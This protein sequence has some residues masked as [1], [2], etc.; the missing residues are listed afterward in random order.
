MDV[1]LTALSLTTNDW[2]GVLANHRRGNP[3]AEWLHHRMGRQE[4][5]YFFGFDAGDT[6]QYEPSRWRCSLTLARPQ[7]RGPNWM[8]KFLTY[9][10]G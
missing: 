1:A 7:R 3:T 8:H 5:D 9:A 6:S 2:P 4:V 10:T